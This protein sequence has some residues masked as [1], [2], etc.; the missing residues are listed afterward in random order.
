MAQTIV[1]LQTKLMRDYYRDFSKYAKGKTPERKTAWVTAFTPVEILEALGIAYYY[2][3]SYAAVIAASEKEQEMLEKS[4]QLGLSGDCCSYSGCFNGCLEAEDGPRGV[5]PRPDVLIATN[6]QCNTLP[7][8]WNTLAEKYDVPLIVL[9]Y[10]GE[11]T[12]RETAF[13]YVAGQ[14]QS[15][16]ARMEELSGNTLDM[17]TL[18]ELIANSRRSVESWNRVISFLPAKEIAPTAL[19]D[20]INFLITA[21]C[22][23]ETAELYQMMADEMSGKPD[24]AEDG[25]LPVFW[26][27]Y[28]LWYHRDRYLSELLEGCRV[29]GSNYITWWSLDYTGED[30]LESLFQAYNYTFLN[31]QQPGRDRRL[32]ALV[33]A[34]GAKCA[35]VLKN[36]SCKCDLVSARN[37]GIPQAEIEMDMID[38]H[39]LDI[40][41][42][43]AR[44]DLLKET[45]EKKTAE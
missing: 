17:E 20:D 45:A 44:I 33:R 42:A 35:V 9:D 7:G 16:I 31:L 2:P 39:F 10:P 24:A 6:N 8:W 29:V 4:A 38:R 43:K 37:V 3:E 40:G 27:G 1:R 26:L 23:P 22:K 5:P 19:F 30:P 34:S 15:L 18:Q 21:R 32:S 12:D 14:H 36:K 11:S 28:P 13:R 41:K 25:R